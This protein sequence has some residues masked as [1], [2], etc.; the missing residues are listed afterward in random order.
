MADMQRLAL[1]TPPRIA[2]LSRTLSSRCRAF[3]RIAAATLSAVPLWKVNR[4]QPHAGELTGPSRVRSFV[5]IIRR[6]LRLARQEMGKIGEV[7]VA[8]GIDDVRHLRLVG[9]ARLILI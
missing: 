6:R 9:A 5:M 3:S 4:R 7:C 2:I 8:Q 1:S